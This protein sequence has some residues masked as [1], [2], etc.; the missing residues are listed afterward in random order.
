VKQIRAPV[1]IEICGMHP[2]VPRNYGG[3]VSLTKNN[4]PHELILTKLGHYHGGE[5]A[6]GN[7]LHKSSNGYHHYV[8]EKR[9]Y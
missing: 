8:F 9:L 2:K 3:E 5:S 4:I 1:K 7:S 6:A